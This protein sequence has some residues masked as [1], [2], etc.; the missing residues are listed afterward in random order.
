MMDL[1]PACRRTA[2][3]LAG[4]TDEQLTLPTPCEKLSLGDLIAHIGGLATAFTAAAGKDFGP[5]TDTPPVDGAP[6]DADWRTAYPRR[7]AELAEA[8]RAA[9]AWQGMTRAGGIDLPGAV[10][11]PVALAEV[12]IHGWDAA[13]AL[14]RPYECDPATAQACLAHLEQFDAAGTEGMFGPA[15]PVADG[16]G[17]LDRIIAMS[18]RDPAWRG[19]G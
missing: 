8:W 14:G 3:L 7:L 16:V 12:V 10:A 9:A 11:G 19:P 2:A 4:V 15:V 18:G 13:Q 6:L 5:L 17:D 1:S